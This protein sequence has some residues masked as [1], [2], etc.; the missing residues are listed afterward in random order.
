MESASGIYNVYNCHLTVV[1]MHVK[2]VYKLYDMNFGD[3]NSK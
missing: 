1:P 2:I 3:E